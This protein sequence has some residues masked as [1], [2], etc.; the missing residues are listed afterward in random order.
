MVA[1]T[2]STLFHAH[3]PELT[4]S[5]DLFPIFYRGDK[6]TAVDEAFGI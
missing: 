6:G 4:I 1:A 3:K 5:L 2:S